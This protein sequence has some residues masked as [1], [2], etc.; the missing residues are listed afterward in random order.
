M[1][2]RRF[3]NKLAARKSRAERESEL[4]REAKINKERKL[5][6]QQLHQRRAALDIQHAEA[7][8]T[9]RKLWVRWPV[10]PCSLMRSVQVTGS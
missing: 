3:K 2:R 5:L 1:L 9:N 4:V 10:N 7:L 6:N 8:A